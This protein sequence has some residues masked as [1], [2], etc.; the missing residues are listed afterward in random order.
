MCFYGG[1]S[2]VI[3]TRIHAPPSRA[4]TL[5]GT[6]RAPPSHD[7]NI[8]AYM[9]HGIETILGTSVHSVAPSVLPWQPSQTA[10]WTLNLSKIEFHMGP[11]MEV[12]R[13]LWRHFIRKYIEVNG[14]QI[15]L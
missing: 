11:G 9:G 6:A 1:H 10:T 14:T 15:K 12:A 8:S 7:D 5:R 4:L 13:I 3:H 2:H